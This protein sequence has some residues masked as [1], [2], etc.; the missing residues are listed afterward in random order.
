MAW[1]RVE[2]PSSINQTKKCS[3]K[4]MMMS[5]LNQPTVI[6]KQSASE[7]SLVDVGSVRGCISWRTGS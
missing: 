6:K 5:W 3:V 7:V 1:Q 2:V 4:L